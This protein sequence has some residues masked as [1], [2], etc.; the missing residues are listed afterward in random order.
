VDYDPA[1]N[2]YYISNKGNGRILVGPMGGPYSTLTTSVSSPHGLEVIADTVYVCDGG[3]IK[4][5]QLPGGALVNTYNISGATFLNGLTS[6]RD[7]MLWFT[8]FNQSRI[9]SLDLSTGQ[10]QVIVANTGTTPNGII[11]DE[12]NNRLIIVNW[13]NNA[14]ILE[15]NLGS[16]SLSTLVNGTGLNNCDGVAL[17]CDGLFYVSS[18]GASAIHT[19]NNDFSVGP[20]LFVNGLS[21][22][23]DIY[24]NALSDTVVS[25]NFGSNTVTFHEVTCI[26]TAVEENTM[27]NIAFGPNPGNGLVELIGLAANHAYRVFDM[28]GRLVEEGILTSE[29]IDLRHLPNGA[30][31]ITF[32]NKQ[33]RSTNPFTYIKTNN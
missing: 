24:Y 1:T 27:N 3:A 29:R 12:D 7:H 11:Y 8:D 17:G 21:Q 22:P 6:D 20:T 32:I 2:D 19:F 31:A 30:F 26:G 5:F 14:D 28:N 15:Y 10:E 25:P 33:G 4:A 23:S 16:N 18:W 13:G 9:H